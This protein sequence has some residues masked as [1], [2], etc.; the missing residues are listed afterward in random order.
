MRFAALTVPHVAGAAT[1]FPGIG[2]GLFTTAGD[3]A[4]P[5][6]EEAYYSAYAVS[7]LCLLIL[8]KRVCAAGAAARDTGGPQEDEDTLAP[9]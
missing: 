5:Y 6:D 4:I 2:T 3:G 9:C 7:V 1:F 8:L